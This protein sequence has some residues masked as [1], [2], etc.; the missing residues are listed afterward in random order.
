MYSVV[1]WYDDEEDLNDCDYGVDSH[2]S[3][4]GVRKG[5]ATKSETVSYD[6]NY[7][8]SFK[9]NYYDVVLRSNR[10]QIPFVIEI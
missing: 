3:I 8:T 9:K 2:C 10:W 5:V 1:G 7:N 6:I 4:C